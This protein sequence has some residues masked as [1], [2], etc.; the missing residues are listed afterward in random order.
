MFVQCNEQASDV[1]LELRGDRTI[2]HTLEYSIDDE[3]ILTLS[4]TLPSG[5][6][7]MTLKRI[8]RNQFLLVNRGFH[9]IN[10]MPYNR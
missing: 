3:G 1:G 9:W 4:G 5:E 2:T 8:D 7:L 6:V 10:E